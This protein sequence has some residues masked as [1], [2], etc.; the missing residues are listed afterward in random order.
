MLPRIDAAHINLSQTPREQA[1]IDRL[2][3]WS[4]GDQQPGC[5]VKLVGLSNGELDGRIGRV[6]PATGPGSHGTPRPGRLP[7]CLS[8]PGALLRLR[9]CFFFFFFVILF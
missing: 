5:G 7:V 1:E 6:L 9:L 3:T 2:C 4:D 8:G